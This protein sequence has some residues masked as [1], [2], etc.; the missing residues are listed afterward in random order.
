MT[1]KELNQGFMRV[2]LVSIMFT[3]GLQLKLGGPSRTRL[4]K[5]YTQ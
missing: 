2:V 4:S 1:E 5:F 3:M